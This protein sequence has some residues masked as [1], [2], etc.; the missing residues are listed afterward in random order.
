MKKVVVKKNRY[1]DSV[2]L[3]GVSD[4]V[5]AIKGVENVE[6]QMATQANRQ[7]LEMLGYEVAADV[8][9]NDLV[10]AI[11][12]VDGT[13]YAAAL[14]LVED[15]IDRKNV[16][17]AKSYADIDEIDMEEDHYDLCQISLPGEYAA[18]QAKKALYKGRC[19][20]FADRLLASLQ[21]CGRCGEVL[22]FRAAG[23]GNA[24]RHVRHC[25]RSP[26]MRCGAFHVQA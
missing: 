16:D 23:W 21:S 5:M 6:A 3:M 7:I 9:A 17:G 2:S 12:A 8:T 24:F 18:E 1:V 11:T 19:G 4:R 26:D 22:G 13:V 14:K 20:A 15:I 25:V 10:I